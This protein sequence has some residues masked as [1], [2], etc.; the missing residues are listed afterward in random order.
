MQVDVHMIKKHSPQGHI[1][2][3][4]EKEV[5]YYYNP[6]SSDIE[7]AQENNEESIEARQSPKPMWGGSPILM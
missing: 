3:L 5:T 1:H 2:K 6:V 4:R 7:H